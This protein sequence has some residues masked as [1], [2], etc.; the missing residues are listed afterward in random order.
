M[1]CS[2]WQVYFL[3]LFSFVQNIKDDGV[4]TSYNHKMMIGLIR[5]ACLNI[6][7]WDANPE[8]AAIIIGY[9]LNAI[10]PAPIFIHPSEVGYTKPQ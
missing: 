9:C 8:P 1:I 5:K 7:Q 10:F 4:K 2:H 6:S 3:V